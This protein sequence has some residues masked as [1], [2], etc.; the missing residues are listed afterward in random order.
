MKR[1]NDLDE[2]FLDRLEEIQDELEEIVRATGERD[3]D[4]YL[5]D[6]RVR[7]RK[8]DGRFFLAL[9]WYRPNAPLGSAIYAPRGCLMSAWYK[10]RDK[11]GLFAWESG[12]EILPR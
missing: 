5:D 9:T 8:A 7:A 11:K 4:N 1:R 3:G 2:E 10:I 12:L 6:L